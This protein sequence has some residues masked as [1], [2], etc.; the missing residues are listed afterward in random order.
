[1]ELLVLS[2]FSWTGNTSWARTVDLKLNTLPT[3]DISQL[4]RLAPVKLVDAANKQTSARFDE[5]RKALD[6]GLARIRWVRPSDGDPDIVSLEAPS[7]TSWDDAQGPV[8]RL[9]GASRGVLLH[10]IMEE[11]ITDQLGGELEVIRARSHVLCEAWAGEQ[12]SSELSADEIAQTALRTWHLPEIAEY[13]TELIAELPIYGRIND[14]ER[15]LVSGRADAVA[16]RNGKPIV[17]FDWKSD[18]IRNAATHAEYS[19]QIA[20]YARV[21]GAQRGAVVY[22][23]SG[24]V[25]W[26]PLN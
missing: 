6:G 10:K 2:D 8:L 22:M 5:E 24:R 4:I 14:D 17:V 15:M 11:L 13:K 18:A 16:Y 12:N 25:E 26:V 19:N 3:L 1:M 21:I 20:Q 9:G 7:V 23:T